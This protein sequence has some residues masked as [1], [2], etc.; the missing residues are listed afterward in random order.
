MK[1][2][3]A[4]LVLVAAWVQAAFGNAA[5]AATEQHL[6][7]PLSKNA[8]MLIRVPR[9]RQAT[10]YTCGVSALQSVLAYWGDE[11][12]EDDLSKACKSD[13]N[14]GTAYRRIAEYAQ[15]RGFEVDI[16]KD[17]HLADLKE[18][19]DKKQPVI[20]L[21]QAWPE[22]QVNYATDWED[23]H[24]VVAI[25]YDADKMYFMD[26]SSLGHYTYIPTPQFEQRWHDTDGKEKLYNFGMVISKHAPT[27]DPEEIKLLE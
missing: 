21:I 7:T 27:Y 25:G 14:K 4:S 1:T 6:Q 10:P 16:R 9:T 2:M 17:M 15:S 5:P 18:L 11:H 20:C 22:R 26:P 24:Y 12:R 13:K 19:L 3:W 8:P 23:G